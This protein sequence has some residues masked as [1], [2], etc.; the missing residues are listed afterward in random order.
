M[1]KNRLLL[2]LLI[3]TIVL[4][5][6]KKDPGIPGSISV[7][8]SATT[9]YKNGSEETK[10]ERSVTLEKTSY[11]QSVVDA[12]VNKFLVNF[13]AFGDA[14]NLP[15]FGIRFLFNQQTNPDG[16]SGTYTFPGNQ[17][18]IRTDFRNEITQTVTENIFF[19]SRGKVSF[20]YDRNSRKISGSIENLEFSIIPN[21]PYDRY[22]VTVNGTFKNV[23]LK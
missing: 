2:C 3:A 19:P 10:F 6:C 14:P 4:N 11:G 23:P 7:N 15:S 21:D 20:Q 16:I 9:F 1:K 13:G 5:S 18:L 22:R 12:G 17:L 8:L